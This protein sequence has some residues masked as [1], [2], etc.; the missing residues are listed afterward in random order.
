M[1]SSN[2]ISSKQRLKIACILFSF[3]QNTFGSDLSQEDL[4]EI[5]IDSEM[6]TALY[7]SIISDTGGFR[8]SNTTE[9]T[10]DI[11]RQLLMLG[12]DTSLA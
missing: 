2:S 7:L 9:K 10:F 5:K 1:E 11:A 12:A 8:Y 4:M 3:E 6:A